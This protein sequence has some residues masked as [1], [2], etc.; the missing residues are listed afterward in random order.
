M[1]FDNSKD[2]R[3]RNSST[4]NVFFLLLCFTR[5][6]TA[7][8]IPG[9]KSIAFHPRQAEATKETSSP[10]CLRMSYYDRAVDTGVRRPD[11]FGQRGTRDFG[12]PNGSRGNWYDDDNIGYGRRRSRGGHY[13][14][15][16]EEN[17]NRY[18]RRRD[19]GE[20]H[21]DY[22]YGRRS[23][24]YNQSN[25]YQNSMDGYESRIDGNGALQTF[26]A[27]DP[28]EYRDDKHVTMETDGRPLEAEVA[29]W[30][31]PNNAPQI[32]NTYSMDGRKN[33]F[34][35][36]FSGS[37]TM[38]VRNTGPGAFPAY[39]SV[40]SSDPREGGGFSNNPG[41][42]RHQDMG[43]TRGMGS[44]QGYQGMGTSREGSVTVQGG[45]LKT[46]SID[47]VVSTATIELESNG[48][49]VNA[50]VELWQGPDCVQQVAEIYSQDGY[51]RP[52]SMEVDLMDYERSYF[53]STTIAI[54]NVGPMAFPF[55][56]RIMY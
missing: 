15:G 39:A 21:R 46:W 33:R 1:N 41:Q 48:M 8:V 53:G 27:E 18:A 29:L 40:V 56:A 45:S 32:V 4:M 23:S 35:G 2:R 37:G 20:S 36:S 49:P 3:I 7:F 38:T 47:D 22:N 16:R 51:K 42:S 24:R 30:D 55:E 43:S 44:T 31:G 5:I 9:S 11:S 19:G 28:Y 10:S 13:G 26:R 54:R 25:R 50:L 12:Q 17:N 14:Q 34:K 6:T 52:Y